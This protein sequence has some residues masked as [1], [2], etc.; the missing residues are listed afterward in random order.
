MGEDDVRLSGGHC[1]ASKRTSAD[2]V[3]DL[4]STTTHQLR[5]RVWSATDWPCAVA[6]DAAHDGFLRRLSATR[7]DS[8]QSS[9][10]AGSKSVALHITRPY[11]AG[12]RRL[13]EGDTPAYNS[14][15][16]TQFRVRLRATR[17]RLQAYD[18]PGRAN[19]PR[20]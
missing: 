8:G 15:R 6:P 7:N 18:G 11:A 12:C 14:C 5:L 9:R 13:T 1:E 20:A 19:G 16:R 2:C 3:F 4:A 10:E 17:E